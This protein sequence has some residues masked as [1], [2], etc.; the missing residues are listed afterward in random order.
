MAISRRIQLWACRLFKG[1]K[2]P[3][4][5]L[6]RSVQCFFFCLAMLWSSNSLN[7]FMAWCLD[8][9]TATGTV[10]EWL[11]LKRGMNFPVMSYQVLFKGEA[12]QF[13]F[14]FIACFFSQIFHVYTHGKD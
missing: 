7:G 4:R 2:I 6:A 14:I 10:P 13:G 11:S 3:L 12:N 9:G 8:S 1:S 5:P